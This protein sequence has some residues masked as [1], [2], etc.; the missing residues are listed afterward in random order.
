MLCRLFLLIFLFCFSAHSSETLVVASKRFVES[1]I[2][3]EVISQHFE[4]NGYTVKRR[5]GLGGTFI[6]Y[7]ALKEHSIDVYV[8]YTGTLAQAV[9]K[10]PKATFSEL[11]ELGRKDGVIVFPSLGFNNAYAMIV[12]GETAEKFNIN[13]ISDLKN[14]PDWLGG[15]TAEFHKRQDGWGNLKKVYGLNNTTRSIENPMVYQALANKKI[16]FAECFTTDS[17]I[18]ELNFRVLEDDL[19]FFPTYV[20]F[21]LAHDKLPEKAQKLLKDLENTLTDEK[22]MALNYKAMQRESISSIAGN[23][24]IAQGLASGSAKIRERAF[25]DWSA[26]AT[27]TQQHL[28]LTFLA[29][30]FATMFAIPLAVLIHNI[31]QLAGPTLG[32]TGLLQTIPSIALLSFMIPLFGIGFTPALVG[33]FL[34][35]LLPIVRNTYT[36]LESIDPKLITAARGIGLY[37]T[38]VFFSIKL[39]ISFPVILAGI[40]TATTIN[41]GTATLA[42]F[43]GAGGLGEPIV[44]GLAMNDSKI[45]LEGALPAAALAVV[46]D[47]IFGIVEKNYVRK[48]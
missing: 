4:N 9:Y 29:V 26:L 2:L 21:P 41:I 42:A 7:S 19:N 3:G 44:M 30:L 24:L 17:I 46:V 16:D 22:M 39:P 34:Y 33:L 36:A 23:F 28:L 38:E 27:R 40:R 14:H 25:I 20:A 15:L 32:F 37:P 43:I 8:E 47:F 35:S 11:Q 13:K 31:K 45:I 18:Q 6:A 1:E 5:F 10:Q 12:R 48:L